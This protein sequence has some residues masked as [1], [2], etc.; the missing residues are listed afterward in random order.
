M[1]IH[2]TNH[3]PQLGVLVQLGFIVNADQDVFGGKWNSTLWPGL[4]HRLD[5]VRRGRV[6]TI[7]VLAALPPIGEPR[8][9]GDV[10]GTVAVGCAMACDRQVSARTK[11]ARA[12]SSGSE[13]IMLAIGHPCV[14]MQP[15][16]AV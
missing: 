11:S 14:P 7:A 12:F 15:T 8:L 2:F 6:T 3:S 9:R 10:M 13:L 5:G 1:D 4:D 16:A